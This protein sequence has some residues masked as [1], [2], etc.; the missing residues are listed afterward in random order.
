LKITPIQR[1]F[2]ESFFLLLLASLIGMAV[3]WK[4]LGNAWSGKSIVDKPS[5]VSQAAIPLPL[6]LM[7]VKELFD[8]NEAVIIDSR[9]RKT[10]SAGH[11]KGAVS[12]PLFEAA[13]MIPEF[14]SRI[15]KKAMLLVYCNGYACEDSVEL[16]KQLIAA[17]YSSVYYFDG[18]FPAWRDAKYPVA[19]VKR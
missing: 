6:G 7:Q 12:L 1:V 10:F 14:S 9:D 19:G 16:G 15:P 18:G 17:G 2:L 5:G 8:K 11:I 13:T 3:N 4:L